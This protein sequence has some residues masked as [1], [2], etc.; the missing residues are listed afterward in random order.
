MSNWTEPGQGFFK[1]ASLIKEAKHGYTNWTINNK[2]DN[3]K[4]RVG[5]AVDRKKEYSHIYIDYSKFSTPVLTPYQEKHLAKFNGNLGK[6]IQLELN[7]LINQ[8]G[9]F[10]RGEKFAGAVSKGWI[11]KKIFGSLGKNRNDVKVRG[12]EIIITNS[13]LGHLGGSQMAIM[14][15]SGDI[16]DFIDEVDMDSKGTIGSV[17]NLQR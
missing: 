4:D 11:D 16:A 12:R 9:E 6:L 1:E 7:N 17:L 5:S 2:P 10:F 15:L 13:K 14:K 3:P 8:K